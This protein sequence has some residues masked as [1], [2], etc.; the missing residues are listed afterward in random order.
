MNDPHVSAL[1]YRVCHNESVDYSK[2]ESASF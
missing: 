2:A 1:H